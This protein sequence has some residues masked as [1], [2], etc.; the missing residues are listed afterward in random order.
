LVLAHNVSMAAVADG[1]V[2]QVTSSP[3]LETVFYM[4]GA[5]L[6]VTLKKR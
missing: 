1:Y 2:K 3:D 4:D 5:G 6:G